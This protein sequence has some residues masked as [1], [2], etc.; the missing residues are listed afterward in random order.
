MSLQSQYSKIYYNFLSIFDHI[1]T[2]CSVC[3]VANYCSIEC[4]D[5]DKEIHELEC[6]LYGK[7]LPVFDAVRMMIRL[8]YK[9]SKV[10][11]LL[12]ML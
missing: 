2:G 9:L 5:R 1:V 10:L 12:G 8:I 4:Q 6:K 11:K 3:T 7:C